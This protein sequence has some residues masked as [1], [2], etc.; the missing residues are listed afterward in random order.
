[1]GGRRATAKGV[2]LREKGVFLPFGDFFFAVYLYHTSYPLKSMGHKITIYLSEPTRAI[3]RG[4]KGETS[5]SKVRVALEAFNHTEGAALADKER[6]IVALR[7]Q[8]LRRDELLRR[9]ERKGKLTPDTLDK[10]RDILEG[11]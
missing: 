5:S 6:L 4:M 9:I 1:V 2:F 7:R 11:F 3:L 8:I 10:M